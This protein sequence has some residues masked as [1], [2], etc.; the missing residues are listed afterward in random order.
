MFSLHDTPA[1]VAPSRDKVDLFPFILSDV[2][3]PKHS[4]FM[5]EGESPGIPDPSGKNFRTATRARKWIVRWDGI[6]LRAVHIDAE[7][8]PQQLHWILCTI[9]GVASRAAIA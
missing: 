1:I 6:R 7:N 5:I 3:K 8:F 4:R 9:L 2:G